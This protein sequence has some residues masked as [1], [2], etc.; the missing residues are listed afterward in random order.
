MYTHADMHKY[1][2]T[3]IETPTVQVFCTHGRRSTQI[4]LQM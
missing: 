3:Y 2:T 1:V 4:V